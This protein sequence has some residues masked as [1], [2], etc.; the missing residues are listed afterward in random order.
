MGIKAT[1]P[2]HD[3][4]TSAYFFP[5]CPADAAWRSLSNSYC[6]DAATSPLLPPCPA[7]SN[8][9]QAHL[10][11]PSP[12][13]LSLAFLNTLSHASR[14]RC[15]P[16]QRIPAPSSDRQ[17]CPITASSI[18]VAVR[19]SGRVNRV[20][21]VRPRHQAWSQRPHMSMKRQLDHVLFVCLGVQ[22]PRANTLRLGPGGRGDRG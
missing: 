7:G 18:S 17:S 20:R 12:C 1:S 22:R 4:T 3:M 21:Y 6:R 16:M 11:G 19:A 9:L 15:G 10:S 5:S 8:G 13:W 14:P 2:S